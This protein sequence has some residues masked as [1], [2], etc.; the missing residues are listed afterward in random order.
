[1]REDSHKKPSI[2]D[3]YRR[4]RGHHSRSRQ[5]RKGAVPLAK[6]GRRGKKETRGLHPSGN[7]EV[8]VYRPEDL[9]QIEENQAARIAS[10][11]GGRKRERILRTAH[12]DDVHVLN[13]DTEQFETKES[14][15]Q[16]NEVESE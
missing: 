3:S 9:Q 14:S 6:A 5:K 1:M 12:Q 16:D 15:N 7:E 13:G 4:P 2:P 10:K 8:L 11:V